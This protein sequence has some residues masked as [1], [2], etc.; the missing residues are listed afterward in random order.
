MVAGHLQKKKGL[1][2]IVLNYAAQNGK[3]KN[4]WIATG[5]PV[6]GNKKKA[7]EMLIEARKNF[8]PDSAPLGEDMLFADF[9]E[10]WL[11]IIRS[12]IQPATYASYTNMIKCVICPYFRKKGIAL[13]LL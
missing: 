13:F 2:Y 7:E 6:K 1:F 3:R 8:V 12:S 9:M 11:E 4:K 5:L 10:Q